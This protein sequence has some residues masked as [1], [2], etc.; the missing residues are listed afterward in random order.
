MLTYISGFVLATEQV[1]KTGFIIDSVSFF[2]NKPAGRRLYL[3]PVDENCC[4]PASELLRTSQDT[5]V[6]FV[7]AQVTAVNSHI[8]HRKG[9]EIS[10]TTRIVRSYIHAGV[11]A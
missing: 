10:V 3:Y 5:T 7:R 8:G 2:D 9:P 4:C 1:E 11:D 6:D